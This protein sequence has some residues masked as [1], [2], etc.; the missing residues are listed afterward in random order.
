TAFPAGAQLTSPKRVAVDGSV[1]SI[2]LTEEALAASASQ[3]QLMRLQ[4]EASLDLV[5]TV[6]LS[7][8]GVTLDAGPAG[9][10]LPQPQYQVDNRPLIWDG[11]RFGY[12]ANGQLSLIEGIS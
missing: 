9:P 1:A 10:G 11:E 2:D 5:T 6:E 8:E 4:A 12:F 7:V 3:R